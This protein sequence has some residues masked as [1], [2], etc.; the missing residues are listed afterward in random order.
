M[1]YGLNLG[2]G[3]V[4]YGVFF[5]YSILFVVAYWEFICLETIPSGRLSRLAPPLVFVVTIVESM[6]PYPALSLA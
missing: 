6:A 1:G 4:P 5:G 2:Q 3:L